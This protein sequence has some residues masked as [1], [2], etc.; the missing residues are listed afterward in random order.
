[1][2]DLARIPHETAAYPFNAIASLFEDPTGTELHMA[3][4][5]VSGDEDVDGE[6]AAGSSLLDSVFHHTIKVE[7]DR[8]PEPKREVDK[9]DPEPKV[10]LFFPFFLEL[11]PQNSHYSIGILNMH[12]LNSYYQSNAS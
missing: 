10:G 1:M 2:L 12:R 4:P 3:S 9:S 7:Q 11:L 5:P 8:E 6:H